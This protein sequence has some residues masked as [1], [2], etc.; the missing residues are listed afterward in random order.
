M[1]RQEI[2]GQHF[3]TTSKHP[4]HECVCDQHSD[5]WSN[6]SPFLDRPKKLV[7][8]HSAKHL[9][10][11]AS[12]WTRL[13]ASIWRRLSHLKILKTTRPLPSRIRHRTKTANVPVCSLFKSCE[14]RHTIR[15]NAK[16][17][18]HIHQLFELPILVRTSCP[19]GA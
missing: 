15:P 2:T 19:R 7:A 11:N 4:N 12:I 3:G 6:L 1:I 9:R 14:W 17:Q 16:C 5:R 18:T 8:L 13:R 10:T